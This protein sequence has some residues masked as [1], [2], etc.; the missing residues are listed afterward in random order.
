MGN[1]AAKEENKG[2]A[3]FVRMYSL[4]ENATYEG[5]TVRT[6]YGGAKRTVL[7]SLGFEPYKS[8]SGAN[9]GR[10][11][12]E[13]WFTEVNK[14]DEG[15]RYQVGGVMPVTDAMFQE[16][17]EQREKDSEIIRNMKNP[18][19]E[20]LAEELRKMDKRMNFRVVK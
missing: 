11:A 8:E 15:W 7:G 2:Y 3:V 4:A 19:M 10:K 20:H 6:M 18:V 9:R 16:M 1:M 14:I 17:E 13:E 12:W 5:G